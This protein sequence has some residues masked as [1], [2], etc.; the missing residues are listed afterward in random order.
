MAPITI[1]K[2]IGA[3]KDQTSISIAKVA[4][5][6][7]PDLEVL[8]VKATS[9][10]D[11]L[12]D[13]KY[14]REILYLT[15]HSNGY[16]NAFVLAISKRLGKTHDWIVALKALMLVHKLLIN[17][18]PMLRHEIMYASSRGTRILNMSD[19]RDE[20][21]LYSWDHS[22]FVKTYALYLEH[23][24]EFMLYDRKKNGDG[25]RSLGR[26]DVK[27]EVPVWEMKPERVLERLH[28][29]LRVL[30]RFLVCKPTGGAKNSRMVLVALHLIVKDSFR[31]YVDICEVLGVLLDGFQEM[32]YA[33]CVKGF[34]AYAG[35][36]KKID[37]LVSFYSWCKDVGIAHSSDYPKVKKITANLLGTLEGFLRDRGNRL[38]S[39]GKSKN[40][41]SLIINT[42]LAS[43][44]NEMKLLPSSENHT[45]PPPKPK[46]QPVTDDLLNLNDGVDSAEEQGQKLALALF[47][48]PL[49]S[50]TNGSWEAFP[51]NRDS[52]I[53]S[54][55]QTAAAER[56]KADWEVVLV[57]SASNLS[58]QKVDMGGKL[59][60][61][62]LDGMYDQGAMRQH[63]GNA[64]LNGG[65]ASSVAVGRNCAPVLALPAPDG[66]VHDQED[67]FA[68]SLMVPPP[69]YVQ[70][71]DLEKK[72]HLL[73]NE[74]QLWQQYE[75]DGMQGQLSFAKVSSGP[76]GGYNGTAQ[77]GGYYHTPNPP[78]GVVEQAVAV[79]QH[80]ST[81][82]FV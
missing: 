41:S 25:Y 72:Q 54:A 82:S 33:D 43:E 9:H 11:D 74:Q 53:T 23:K 1:R 59:D 13:E 38:K 68:A 35:A 48:G 79:H 81:H 60:P 62:L 42:E 69:S 78:Q 29:L 6:V 20:S 14:I 80:T 40:D 8:I 51:S 28:L 63:V 45:P 36:A 5:A 52:K 58:N 19:F 67:P 34:D 71:V 64:Q 4:G 57:E 16:V 24:L 22:D 61:L 7:A 73:V 56:D 50:N 49:G 75:S 21:H 70:I 76:P 46:T 17:G 10:D 37:E 39:E 26:G 3:V 47:S 31:L 66:I 77:L 65:S 32:D 12:A 18:D 44:M 55:W 2:A 30:D 27:V 15:S